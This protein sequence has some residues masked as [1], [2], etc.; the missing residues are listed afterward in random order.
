VIGIYPTT[1]LLEPTARSRSRFARLRIGRGVAVLAAL[2]AL[3]APASAIAGSPTPTK[4]QYAPG[5]QGIFGGGGGGGQH[6][7]STSSSSGNVGSLP[8]TGLDVGVLALIGVGL[9]ASGAVLRRRHR[10]TGERAS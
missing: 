10:V 9:L 8:F 4:A 3:A 2:V 6:G 1:K 7:P 5:I